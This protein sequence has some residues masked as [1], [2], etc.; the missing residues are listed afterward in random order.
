MLVMY[1]FHIALQQVGL[2]GRTSLLLHPVNDGVGRPA[3][4]ILDGFAILEE[5]Q[6]GNAA[7]FKLF[8]QCGLFCN[9]HL[10]ELYW[11]IFLCQSFG[12]FSVLRSQSFAVSTRDVILKIAFLIKGGKAQKAEVS[13]QRRLCISTSAFLKLV[14]VP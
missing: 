3:V 6:G 10:S 7:D 4:A 5:L 11:G 9:V 2:A 13:L 8:G 1:I 14:S 12:G